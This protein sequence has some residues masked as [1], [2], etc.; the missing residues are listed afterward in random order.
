MLTATAACNPIDNR[1]AGK[2]RRS[3]ASVVCDRLRRSDQEPREARMRGHVWMIRKF[4]LRRWWRYE[5]ARRAG[6]RIPYTECTRATHPGIFASLDAI[7]YVD[8]QRILLPGVVP[9]E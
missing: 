7:G 1:A 4:G 2:A 3:I 6:V 5:K 8:A 9:P